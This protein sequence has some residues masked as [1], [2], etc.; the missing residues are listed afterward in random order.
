MYA[1]FY[2][3]AFLLC[4]ANSRSDCDR[5]LFCRAFVHAGLPG[6][7]LPI[8]KAP[9]PV[10]TAA[11]GYQPPKIVNHPMNAAAALQV[12]S[13]APPAAQHPPAPMQQPWPASGHHH[14][15]ANP[16]PAAAAWPTTAS[17]HQAGLMP[18]PPQQA[19][20]QYPPQ[21]MPPQAPPAAAGTPVE[22]YLWAMAPGPAGQGLPIAAGDA[23]AGP[24]AAAGWP[25]AQPGGHFVLAQPPPA[26]MAVAAPG[27]SHRGRQG[28]SLL[29]T[30]MGFR[31]GQRAGR[32]QQQRRMA[33]R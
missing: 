22:A 19:F 23:F 18:L 4:I 32:R 2:F 10:P 12:P 15:G 13:G 11:A 24:A 5:L 20:Q 14:T 1:D 25:Q 29:A 26:S 8:S 9:V 6:T 31:M 27:A 7:A 28:P 17:N 33:R 30:Y 3:T 16:A 21:P